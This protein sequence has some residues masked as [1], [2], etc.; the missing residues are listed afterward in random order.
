VGK[1]G[2]TST[3]K[4]SPY[5][6]YTMQG[7]QGW[8][9]F[10]TGSGDGAIAQIRSELS[11]ELEEW[12]HIAVTMNEDGEVTHYLNGELNGEGFV[13]PAA[14]PPVDEDTNLYIG[15][16]QDFVTNMN[17]FLDDVAIFNEALSAEQIATIMGGD[18]S[19][20]IGGGLAGDYNGNGMLDE[21]D[22][23]ELGDAAR[24]GAGDLKYD[25]NGDNVVDNADHAAWVTDLKNSWIGD[26]NLDDEFNSADFVQVFQRGEYEDTVADNSQWGDGDW[27]NDQEFDSAD[28]VAAFTSGGYELGPRPPA[29]VA[30]VPEPA[31]ALL[32]IVGSLF[33]VIRRR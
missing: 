29:A 14:V 27:N 30:A 1:T 20:W 33:L 16:R 13:D 12:Q 3:N 2:V 18:F 15:S 8:V 32:L 26:A 21:A 7:G 6:V 17:G 4:P 19:A 25:V 22:L 24:G 11:P 28:F 5:D 10:Y 23:N 31:G 9:S